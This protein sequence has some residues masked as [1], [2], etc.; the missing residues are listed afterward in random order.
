MSNIMLGSSQNRKTKKATRQGSL[1]FYVAFY[2]QKSTPK[3]YFY[4]FLY[5]THSKN[6][7]LLAWGLG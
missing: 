2:A 4:R 3:N 5:F 6:P 1:L 7:T